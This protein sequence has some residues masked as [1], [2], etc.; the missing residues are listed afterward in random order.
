MNKKKLQ[1]YI[2]CILENVLLE[3]EELDTNI[4]DATENIV[5]NLSDQTE[6][7]INT[8]DSIEDS[9]GASN[10]EEENLENADNIDNTEPVDD[11]SG[12]NS[13]GGTAGG[14]GG[15]GGVSFGAASGTD[16]ISNNETT[17]QT[18]TE[19]KAENAEEIFPEDPVKETVEMALKLTKT[20]GNPQEIVNAVKTNIQKYFEDP[21]D[22]LEVVQQLW[23]SGDVKMRSVAVK[24][25]MFIRGV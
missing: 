15:G 23:D 12:F 22:S 5:D 13:F 2:E 20:I 14:G 11:T 6:T 24:L 3:Q 19:Q 16:P 9:E 1:K 18:D 4:T 25:L 17:E 8:D 21:I 7:D 10:T